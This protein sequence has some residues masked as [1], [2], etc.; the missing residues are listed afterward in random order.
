[1]TLA[2]C[3]LAFVLLF[4]VPAIANADEEAARVAF[5]KGV[6][7]YDRKQYAEALKSFETAYAEKPSGGIK[8]NIALCLKSLGRSVEAATAFDEALDEG[9]ATLKPET[10]AAIERELAELG[11][12]VATVHMRV[13][14]ADSKPLDEAVVSVD[15]TKLPPGA[16]RKPIR[17]QQGIH[18][19]TAHVDGLADPPPKKLALLLGQPVDAT[20]IVTKTG[21]ATGG[22]STLTVRANV[23]DATIM[24]D[25]KEVGK[26]TWTG[27]L[28]AGS[29]QLEVSAPDHRTAT[30]DVTVP[31]DTTM[32]Y[33]IHL[34]TRGEAPGPYDHVDRPP[35]KKK[36]LYIVP[37]LAL[38]G[39]SYRLAEPLGEV[40]SGER[41]GFFGLGL[42]GRFG[43][44]F[45]RSV[46]FEL[47]VE[48]AAA[49]AKYHLKEADTRDTETSLVLWRLLP[50]VRYASPGKVRFTIGSS[51]GLQGASVDS[52]V[53]QG[54]ETV[55]KKGS[56][57]GFS[58]LS[59]AGLQVE[60]GSVFFEGLL[61]LDVYGTGA[62]KDEADRRL[63]QASPATRAGVRVGVGIPF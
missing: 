5:R 18:T 31:A 43:R 47:L 4:F 38:F 36:D 20:F 44:R 55:N 51:V 15:G 10:K 62:V 17:L 63:L 6:D 21:T 23:D 2:R 19:F 28:P 39:A 3:L 40:P 45:G 49:T 37:A 50:G 46:S 26:G 52:K 1:M 14:G 11:K 61:F 35:P 7:L 22:E 16:H 54:A 57:I 33:P 58:W 8:Q 30:I 56:G 59:D 29:H 12:I 48:L 27:K 53:V 60:T 32:E 24:I 41:R 25:G 34:T 42:S 13:I 9:Q